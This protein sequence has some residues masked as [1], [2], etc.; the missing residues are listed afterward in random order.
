MQHYAVCQIP[1][2]DLA[3]HAELF[4]VFLTNNNLTIA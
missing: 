1:L 3:L 4:S 2:I